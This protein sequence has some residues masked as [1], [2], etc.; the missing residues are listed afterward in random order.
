MGSSLIAACG[1]GE[2]SGDELD[3]RFWGISGGAGDPGFPWVPGPPDFD[4]G[5]IY[6]HPTCDTLDGEWEYPDTEYPELDATFSVSQVDIDEAQLDA[7]NDLSY[8]AVAPRQ[9]PSPPQY[10]QDDLSS[11]LQQLSGLS[12]EQDPE[13]YA[14][15]KD[16][17]YEPLHGFLTDH[18]LD[19]ELITEL[20]GGGFTIDELFNPPN[21]LEPR[22]GP[23]DLRV[24]PQ[25]CQTITANAAQGNELRYYP[26]VELSQVYTNKVCLQTGSSVEVF[27]TDLDLSTDTEIHIWDPVQ[28]ASVAYSDDDSAGELSSRATF[29]NDGGDTCVTVLVLNRH[30]LLTGLA[31][32][33][34]VVSQPGE[35]PLET[36]VEVQ[37]RS[38]EVPIAFDAPT[39][40]FE[41]AMTR[42]TTLP[43]TPTSMPLMLLSDSELVGFDYDSGVG[44]A[45]KVTR[46]QLGSRVPTRALV[47]GRS[48]EARDF[49][50]V[51]GYISPA[52]ELAF[53]MSV[54]GESDIP[55]DALP[56][57][58]GL[59]YAPGLDGT[60]LPE[61]Y[62]PIA[63][64]GRVDLILDDGLLL[65]SNDGDGDGISAR[66]EAQLCTCDPSNRTDYTG[67]WY[68]WCDD[69][70]DYL[71]PAA[72]ALEE[73][74]TVWHA[75]TDHDGLTDREETFGVE[76]PA[77]L[78]LF[79][80]ERV[81]RTV[82][83]PIMGADALHK[84]MFVE[85]DWLQRPGHSDPLHFRS[86]ATKH[87]AAN[88]TLTGDFV[89]RGAFFDR[90]SSAFTEGSTDDLRNPDGLDGIRMHVDVGADPIVTE[91]G[92][93]NHCTYVCT[94]PSDCMDECEAN[95]E[96]EG[97]LSRTRAFGDWGGGASVVSTSLQ[98]PNTPEGAAAI[99][100]YCD[101]PG[102]SNEDL[103]PWDD[104]KA[105]PALRDLAYLLANNAHR[106]GFL[107][108]AVIDPYAF[109]GGQAWGPK[110]GAGLNATTFVHESGHMLAIQHYGKSE[111]G[112]VNC[113]P[114][115]LSI[116]NYAYNQPAAGFSSAN[117]AT[118]TVLNPSNFVERDY[119][120][121]GLT[122]EFVDLLDGGAF[123][124][125]VDPEGVDAQG[126]GLADIDWNLSRSF[127]PGTLRGPANWCPGPGGATI[128][129]SEFLTDEEEN[130]DWA[131]DENGAAPDLARIDD[132]LFAFYVDEDGDLIYRRGALGP[133]SQG[134]CDSQVPK[135][136]GT[137]IECID[138]EDPEPVELPLPNPISGVAVT[139]WSGQFVIAYNE[140]R[141]WGVCMLRI[142]VT[143]P[144]SDDGELPAASHLGFGMPIACGDVEL[145]T[146]PVSDGID[147]SGRV[148]AALA[149]GR[150]VGRIIQLLMPDPFTTAGW[151]ITLARTDTGALIRSPVAP[152]A[153]VWPSPDYETAGPGWSE[154]ATTCGVFPETVG[155]TIKSRFMC[156]D[157]DT[158]RWV[159]D[160]T[161]APREML[162]KPSLAFHILRDSEGEPVDPVNLPGQWWVAFVQRDPDPD[163]R[164]TAIQVSDVI[165]RVP[166]PQSFDHWEFWFEGRHGGS[167]SH[168]TLG[169]GTVLYEDLDIGALKGMLNRVV[170]YE[171]YPLVDGSFDAE[172]RTGNDFRVMES[173][174]CR[175]IRTR[176]PHCQTEPS[177]TRWGY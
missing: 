108:Y 42:Y 37:L 169:S 172:M 145:V 138:W 47:L 104:E 137:G 92:R 71:D 123:K 67:A 12:N 103:C 59:D 116:M 35:P 109:S 13:A 73:A 53:R 31:R 65:A 86:A 52:D 64:E 164:T 88:G 100:A 129:A 72:D 118:S 174:L 38:F 105:V 26:N 54:D 149:R 110:L 151:S 85:L 140:V 132:N 10:V 87:V 3:P 153:A 99:E 157:R 70:Y 156:W 163:K 66:T 74:E 122:P 170:G 150:F 56:D 142:A 165:S 76:L 40:S 95:L 127:E 114:N 112:E 29:L 83:L 21:P 93:I 7:L 41:V 146:L 177:E 5:D 107:Y 159:E 33:S 78:V 32:V 125:A 84:D 155:D 144:P 58:E 96:T 11:A 49:T 115:Y 133:K 160:L 154:I 50:F 136:I 128:Q 68:P 90:I 8:A 97:R 16:A 148:L 82:A 176:D 46:D 14:D 173:S 69:R 48:L 130:P 94:G 43:R 6:D 18:H 2:D 101:G 4:V 141:P 28:S 25:S 75:D 34:T 113:K 20:G 98:D 63:P 15:A 143:G 1:H 175:G 39:V 44:P 55:L 124:Y 62:P 17:I 119:A 134:S 22:P 89:W 19:T 102:A 161:H 23:I 131:A 57:F 126:D 168:V 91:V 81:F 60:L 61:E 51:D 9:V 120:V 30:P 162:E 158:G 166:G 79:E 167:A 106:K 121:S 77:E 139:E 171:F 135:N 111:W 45:A 27:T 24:R 36:D 117:T 152:G 147:P 80:A